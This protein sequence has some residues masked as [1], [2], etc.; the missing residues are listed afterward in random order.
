MMHNM[1]PDE[2]E[3]IVGAVSGYGGGGEMTVGAA[4]DY[5]DGRLNQR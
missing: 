3:V 4:S 5:G 2:N 1:K